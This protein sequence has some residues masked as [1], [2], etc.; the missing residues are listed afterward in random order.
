MVQNPLYWVNTYIVYVHNSFH[1]CEIHII[2]TI[3]SIILF[4]FVKCIVHIKQAKLCEG[5]Y[6]NPQNIVDSYLRMISFLP[7][8]AGNI[9]TLFGVPWKKDIGCNYSCFSGPIL[10]IILQAQNQYVFTLWRSL[11]KLM[12]PQRE[13]CSKST[14]Q[15]ITHTHTHSFCS[16][17]KLL[18][19]QTASSLCLFFSINLTH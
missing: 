17:S 6:T 7:Y 18:G 5:Y 12:L 1:I 14:L 4:I 9:N 15:E 8:L 16:K 2:D 19:I 13:I 10:Y 11:S 3:Y